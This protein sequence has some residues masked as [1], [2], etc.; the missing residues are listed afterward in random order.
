[1]IIVL[2]FTRT[3][4]ADP[5]WPI[6]ALPA[7]EE[8]ETTTDRGPASGL[9]GDCPKGTGCVAVSSI[10]CGNGA[11]LILEFD[12]PAADSTT[13]PADLV[14]WWAAA[15]ALQE[16]TPASIPVWGG[17]TNAIRYRFFD[18]PVPVDSPMK[19]KLR[20]TLQDDPS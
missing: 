7:P 2:T 20:P 18:P 9:P 4:T 6:R 16:L 13:S 11:M 19:W 3:D 1:M 12:P 17:S 8:G 10:V 5:E 14:T 15:A